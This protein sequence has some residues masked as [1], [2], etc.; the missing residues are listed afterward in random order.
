MGLEMLDRFE[1]RINELDS[2]VRGLAIDITTG[3]VV[4][5]I[6]QKKLWKKTGG[7]IKVVRELVK[8]LW[9]YLSILKPEKVP[10]IQR[11][12]T[13]IFER[14]DLFKESLL[15]NGS[16]EGS[17]KASINELRKALEEIAEFT[18]LCR[19]I[20]DDPSEI[21]QTILELRANQQTNRPPITPTKMIRLGNLVKNARDSNGEIADLVT[22][23]HGKLTEVKEEYD[24]LYFS[25]SRNKEG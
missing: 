1:G 24:E 17:A 16:E 20:L 18:S 8:E 13:S 9:E 25:L 11:R 7:R 14:L 22:L 2:V 15:Q 10:S 23:L 4:D 6:P 19:S 12:V 3:T 21:I 5:R